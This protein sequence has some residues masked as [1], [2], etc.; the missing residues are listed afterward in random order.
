MTSRIIPSYYVVVQDFG[1][2]LGLGGEVD[3]ELTRANI[4]DRI[5]SGQYS[6]IQW[7]HYVDGLIV[8][9][10][11]LELLDEAEGELKAEAVNRADRADRIA[12]ERDHRRGLKVA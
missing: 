5:K 11:T 9:D 3:P 6:N 7:I 10:V 12:F 4:I 2:R 8:E 1:G